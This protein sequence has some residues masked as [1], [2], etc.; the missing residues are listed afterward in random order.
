[1]NFVCAKP[2]STKLQVR[3]AVRKYYQT[4]SISGLCSQG[5]INNTSHAK[6][7]DRS[8]DDCTCHWTAQFMH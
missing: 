7:A 6:N 2:S 3:A 4:K 8:N 1:M 5:Y